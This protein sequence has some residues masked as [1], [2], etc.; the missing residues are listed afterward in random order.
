MPEVTGVLLVLVLWCGLDSR[1]SFATLACAL[2]P[3]PYLSPT[4]SSDF[5]DYLLD[6]QVVFRG[7]LVQVEQGMY[8]RRFGE[9]VRAARLTVRDVQ[10]LVGVCEDSV[11]T[12]IK[13]DGWH[14]KPLIPQDGVEVLGWAFRDRENSWRLSGEVLFADKSGILSTPQAYVP[15]LGLRATTGTTRELAPA[16]S[17]SLVRAIAERRDDHALSVFEGATG[18]WRVRVA[19]AVANE[20]GIEFGVLPIELAIGTGKRPSL[21]WRF[22]WRANCFLD[23][24]VGDE[25]LLPARM[26]P[27]TSDVQVLEVCPYSLSVSDGFSRG[28]GVDTDRVED[29][30]EFSSGR[31]H[32]REFLRAKSQ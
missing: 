4:D 12:V 25:L 20:R 16:T 9:S 3:N 29:A 5:A 21:V 2:P 11:L 17:I 23:I 1:P 32:V 22:A 13:P 7:R 31:V 27:T 30:L 10:P 6:K 26:Q 19:W 24:Q 14:M 15:N 18:V 28:L 8:G